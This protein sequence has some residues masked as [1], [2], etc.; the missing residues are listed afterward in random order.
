[1]V[2][3]ALLEELIELILDAHDGLVGLGGIG[4]S[5]HLLEDPALAEP[6]AHVLG[7]GL[8]LLVVVEQGLVDLV[9]VLA[10]I[11]ELL[12]EL[13]LPE[14][15]GEVQSRWLRDVQRV[16][17]VLGRVRWNRLLRQVIDVFGVLFQPP[18]VTVQV[19]QELILAQPVPD[20]PLNLLD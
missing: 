5:L 1:M 2:V 3:L 8:V 13:F 9:V 10:A 6:L 7:L 16:H 17:V 20:R 4:S 11:L 14:H 18:L 15:V 12:L 19:R